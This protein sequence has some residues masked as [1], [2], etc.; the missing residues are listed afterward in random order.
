VTFC[1]AF[2]YKAACEKKYREKTENSFTMANTSRAREETEMNEA[3]LI[4]K[5][6]KYLATVPECFFW[7]EH[8]GQY[9]TAGIPDIIVCHKGRFIALEAKV[10]R[11]TPTK[12]QAA[13]IDK[14]RQAGGTA[15]VV[16][17]VEDVQAVIS[18]TEALYDG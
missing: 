8:G 16:Y 14:I 6:R 4:Q 3:A 7:K 15:A 13:T 11:N 10:G 9:G 2:F 1:E 17:S 5:I 12:L 18:E